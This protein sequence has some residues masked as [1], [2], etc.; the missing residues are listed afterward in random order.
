[1]RTSAVGPEPT[2]ST[3]A[4]LSASSIPTRSQSA[5]STASP[6]GGRATSSSPFTRAIPS[7][8]PRCSAW[9]NPTCV[10]TPMEGRAIAQ[11]SATF[12][13]NRAPIS[14]TSA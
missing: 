11:S 1:M 2:V 9:A 6:S 5:L 7:R 4:G 10:I 14:R 3:R 12:P 13:G 8:P